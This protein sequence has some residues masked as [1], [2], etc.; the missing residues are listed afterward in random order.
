MFALRF[1]LAV[2]IAMILI[3]GVTLVVYLLIGGEDHDT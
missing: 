3:G 1:I 2:V